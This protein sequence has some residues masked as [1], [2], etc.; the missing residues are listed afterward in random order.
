MDISFTFSLAGNHGPIRDSHKRKLEF[1][2]EADWKSWI[3]KRFPQEKIARK[4]KRYH[5]TYGYILA[6]LTV[7]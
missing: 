1:N 3:Q 6:N 4:I 2:S 7:N 5:R